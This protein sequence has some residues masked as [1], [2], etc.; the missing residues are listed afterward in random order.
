MQGGVVFVDVGGDIEEGDFVGI[1]FVVVVSDFDWVVGVVDVFE[2]DVFDYLVVVYVEV[3]DDVFC[4]CYVVC[5][6]F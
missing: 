1:L 6:R 2:F 4:Q 3:G 5:F